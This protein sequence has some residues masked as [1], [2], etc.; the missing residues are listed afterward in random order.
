MRLKGQVGADFR[1]KEGER[2]IWPVRLEATLDLLA[3]FIKWNVLGKERQ[4]NKILPE[5]WS[6]AP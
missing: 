4:E 1:F 6:H 2:E 3:G 5:I